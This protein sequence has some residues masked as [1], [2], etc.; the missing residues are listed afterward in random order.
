MC[1]LLMLRYCNNN[2]LFLSRLCQFVMQN[3]LFGDTP[4]LESMHLMEPEV[5][6]IKEE[7]RKALTQAAIPLKAYA[8][9][10]EK[11]LELHNTNTDSYVQ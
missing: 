3:L 7:V 4:V 11:H 2:Y 1:Y 8:A 6:A 9:E 10:Y 5:R